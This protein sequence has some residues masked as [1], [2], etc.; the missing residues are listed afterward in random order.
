MKYLLNC[1]DTY[2][3][4][5]VADV[6]TLHDEL[7]NNPSFTLTSFSYK[8][9]YVKLKGEIVDEYQVVTAKKVFN[10]EKDPVSSITITYEV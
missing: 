1:V 3:V 9:K 4:A 10:D 2:R 7:L 6:E 5:T 8:T